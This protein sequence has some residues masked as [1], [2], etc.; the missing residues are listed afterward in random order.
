[1]ENILG[2]GHLERELTPEPVAGPAAGAVGLHVALLAALALYGAAMGLFHHNL[3][4]SRGAGGAMQVS[5]TSA[6]PLPADQ[7]NQN[8]LATETP[9]QAPAQPSPKQ[10]TRSE[11]K[12]IPLPGRDAKQTVARNLQHQ[13]TQPEQNN[14]ARYGEQAGSSMPKAIEGGGSNG[15]TGVG[16]SSFASLYAWYVQQI[17]RTMASKWNK[18]EVNQATPKGARAYIVF[19]LNKFGNPSEV[20]VDR[21]SGSPTLD[22]SCVRAAQRVDSFGSFPAQYNK[23]TL[24]VSFYCEY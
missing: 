9:S 2:G 18:Y 8:V 12:A 23:S 11:E 24:K 5:L 7:I 10:Q 17:T 16:D 19:T 3:W 6:L 1:M 4:G 14:V 20:A 21:S 22:S 15:P 13:Q